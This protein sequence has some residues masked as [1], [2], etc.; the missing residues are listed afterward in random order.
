MSW[1]HQNSLFFKLKVCLFV[2]AF[3]QI[4]CTN[5]ATTGAKGLKHIKVWWISYATKKKKKRLDNIP[6][7][8]GGTNFSR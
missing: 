3:C 7:E 8:L 1:K 5:P 6:S 4:N 2:W